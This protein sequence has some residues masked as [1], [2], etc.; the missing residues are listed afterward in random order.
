MY[1]KIK[2]KIILFFILLPIGLIIGLFSK[3]SYYNDIKN[4][5]N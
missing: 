3:K 4:E 1:L 2:T 5:I